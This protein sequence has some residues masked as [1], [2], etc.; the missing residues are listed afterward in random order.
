MADTTLQCKDVPVAPAWSIPSEDFRKLFNETASEMKTGIKW[1]NDFA[2]KGNPNIPDVYLDE[3]QSDEVRPQ[4]E[5]NMIVCGVL[6]KMEAKRQEISKKAYEKFLIQKSP[7]FDSERL[8]MVTP[9]E[10]KWLEAVGPK[11]NEITLRIYGK[12]ADFDWEKVKVWMN[13]PNNHID[14]YSLLHFN[15]IQIKTVPF[16]DRFAS[17]VPWFPKLLQYNALWPADITEAELQAISAKYKDDP[18]APIL[19]P[20]T[21]VERATPEDIE[22]ANKGELLK[23]SRG[24]QVEWIVDGYK[25]TNIALHPRYRADFSELAALLRANANDGLDP[26][27]K[28][29]T[30]T[31]ADACENGNF[32]DL[33]RADLD[34]TK[35][36]IML[37]YFP[38]EGYWADNIKFPFI[39][40]IGIRQKI[41]PEEMGKQLARLQELENQTAKILQ[42]VGA[43]YTPRIFDT[44]EIAKTNQMVWIYSNG[45]FVRAFPWSD[46]IGHDYPKRTYPGIDVHRTV[47][48]LDPIEAT[49]QQRKKFIGMLSPK[50]KDLLAIKDI[51]EGVVY[52]EGAHGC[53]MRPTDITSTGKT[54]GQAFGGY[55]G[56]LTESIAYSGELSIDG[57]DKGNPRNLVSTFFASMPTIASSEEM[58]QLMADPA[59]I[60]DN[61]HEPAVTAIVGFLASKGIISLNEDKTLNIKFDKIGEHM[62]AFYTEV[63]KFSGKGDCAGFVAFINKNI[64][65][66]PKEI[67]DVIMTATSTTGKYPLLERTEKITV[68]K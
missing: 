68:G 17:S 43:T 67:A 12:E 8:S 59:N 16:K 5:L 26:E 52:H 25:V 37:T 29:Y 45:G 1:K 6:S 14:E 10:R 65:A 44:T 39:A 33:L 30:L 40:E 48:M 66:L 22:R 2:D 35:G 7:T 49:L 21:V 63:V 64:D 13:D 15:R 11:F 47:T 19:L 18:N 9:A 53:G 34:Q 54:L 58:K 57:S 62:K 32:I 55:W 31:M 61:A 36:N 46:P 50:E 27:F 3:I 24:E 41:S 56:V 23:N 28:Q 51:A 60:S 42:S 4:E 38:H 20:F